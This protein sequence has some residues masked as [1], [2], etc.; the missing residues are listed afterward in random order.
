MLE[1]TLLRQHT[2]NVLM[3]EESQWV[4]RVIMKELLVELG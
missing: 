2:G 4:I 3:G 1:D